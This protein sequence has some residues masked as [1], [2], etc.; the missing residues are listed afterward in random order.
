VQGKGNSL[1]VTVG[2]GLKYRM[3][4]NVL[5]CYSLIGGYNDM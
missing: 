3:K 4:L 1:W 5:K 2:L